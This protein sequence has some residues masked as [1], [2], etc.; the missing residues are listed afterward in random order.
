MTSILNPYQERA[1][2]NNNKLNYNYSINFEPQK[3]NYVENVFITLNIS[4]NSKRKTL[5]QAPKDFFDGLINNKTNVKKHKLYGGKTLLINEI[6]YN[7]QNLQG[8]A[9]IWLVFNEQTQMIDY[10]IKITPILKN[11]STN[12]NKITK[13]LIPNLINNL[14]CN[15][16]ILA[17]KKFGINI[18]EQKVNQ[19]I[20]KI[21]RWS[22]N[23]SNIQ[24]FLK[25]KNNGPAIPSYVSAFTPFQ[26]KS[27]EN[28][29]VEKLLVNKGKAF[30][31]SNNNNGPAV[32]LNSNN[33][34]GPAFPLNSN[35]NNGPAF[36]LN[37]N[38][39]NG[40]AV[41]LNLKNKKK[42][43]PISSL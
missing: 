29:E 35:K 26:K 19:T 16:I 32:P 11:N 39:N 17:L 40:P 33:N 5:I 10:V 14:D 3:N 31:N 37:S 7:Y 20:C 30:L 4:P 43:R 23:V 24:I 6:D 25:K 18:D 13:G 9:K 15:S 34:N 28:R 12:S 38:K 1:P 41:P 8:T 2:R 27:N 42:F 36:P 22:F 21:F